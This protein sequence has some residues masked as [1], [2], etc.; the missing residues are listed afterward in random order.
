[1]RHL[2]RRQAARVAAA[3]QPLVVVGDEAAHGLGEAA[4]LLEQAPAVAR[5]ALDRGELLV[6]QRARLLQDL[7]RHGELADVVQQAADGEVAARG[8]GELELLADL[9][10]EQR[11]AAGVLLG[12]VVALAQLRTIRARTRGPRN[13]SSEATSSVAVRSPTSGREAPARLMS[14]AAGIAT[15]SD[16]ADLEQVADVEAERHRAERRAWCRA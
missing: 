11:D 14:S 7:E 2:R 6:G 10:G 9:R 1:M 12:G 5:V 16:A 4:E 13:A 15:S 3:V 8:R